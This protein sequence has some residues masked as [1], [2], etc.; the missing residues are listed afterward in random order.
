VLF[1]TGGRP[2]QSS[3]KQIFRQNHNVAKHYLTSLLREPELGLG[4]LQAAW[5]C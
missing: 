1:I 4:T 2:V 5:I 3:Y